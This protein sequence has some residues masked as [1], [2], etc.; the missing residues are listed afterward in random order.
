MNSVFFILLISIIV[1][2]AIALFC[3]NKFVWIYV[4]MF[5]GLLFMTFSNAVYMTIMSNILPGNELVNTSLLRIINSVHRLSI[6]NIRQM[7]LIG[8]FLVLFALLIAAGAILKRK[9]VFFIAAIPILLFY[10]WMSLPDVSFRFYLAINSGDKNIELS[11]RNTIYF[12]SLV[13]MLIVFG[14]FVFPFFVVIYSYKHTILIIKKRMLLVFSL[15]LAIVEFLIVL[16][17]RFNVINSLVSMNYEIFYK[18]NVPET[19]SI[20]N[21][22]AILVLFATA[23][24]IIAM[25]RSRISKKYF[26]ASKIHRLYDIYSL[27]KN[28]RMILHTYKNMFF[29]VRQLS[30]ISLCDSALSEMTKNNIKSIN[31]LADN[32]LFG[33]TSHIRMLSKFELD[34]HENDIANSIDLAIGK[35]LDE[36]KEK[37]HIDYRVNDRIISSD[38]FYLSEVFYNI[39]KNAVEAVANTESPRIDISVEREDNWF[40]IKIC[41]NGCGI[42]SEKIKDIFKPLVSY[43]QG[44]DNWGIGLYYSHKIVSALNGYLF[45]YSEA[46]KYTS[47]HI[48]LPKNIKNG[49][50]FIGKNKSSSL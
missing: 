18:K 45:V 9:K 1:L 12:L 7:S 40:L 39:L 36:D 13:K 46:G 41:D 28:L 48:Y 14:F 44:A 50:G 6:S 38:L 32:A 29:A 3:K 49:G 20:N 2:A 22:L 34:F 19:F 15:S 37:I 24:S 27:D 4:C 17:V 25:Q 5:I 10:V 11:A 26:S 33:I 16:L 21:N 23:V 8:E 31:K 42:D 30:D 35:L 43:K 47:F